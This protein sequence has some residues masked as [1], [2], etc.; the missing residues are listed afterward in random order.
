MMMCSGTPFD[1]WK[2]MKNK[3]FMINL[4][5]RWI[6]LKPNFISLNQCL[7]RI[8]I[9][10]VNSKRIIGFHSLWNS[11]FSSGPRENHL[12]SMSVRRSPAGCKWFRI[13]HSRTL[14]FVHPLVYERRFVSRND[15]FRETIVFGKTLVVF[16]QTE[17]FWFSQKR[18]V[19]SFS[20]L[21]K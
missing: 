1:P 18:F 3:W 9:Q 12:W 6:D 7:V 15:F 11:C 4:F 5:M 19:R 13:F 10:R 20:A 17:R 8:Q 14:L 21:S 2:N 16:I